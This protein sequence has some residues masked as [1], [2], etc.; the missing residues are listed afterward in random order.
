[1]SERLTMTADEWCLVKQVF[2]ASLDRP[3]AERAT[4]VAS[5]CGSQP[6]VHAAVLELLEFDRSETR[7]SGGRPAA[8]DHVLAPG[9]LVA[10]RFRVTRLIAAGGMGEVFEVWD[11]WLRLK[12]ALKTLRP[13]LLGDAEALQ[14]FKRE[15]LVARGVAHENVCRVFDFVEHRPESASGNAITPCF[16]MELLEGESLA[17][18]LCRRRPLPPDEA[19]HIARQVACG[20]SALHDRGIIHRDLKPSN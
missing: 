1:M 5:A 7:L 8:D 2:D 17:E 16:T 6:V 9:Q 20:L 11:E 18:L 13:E 3:E 15:L 12:I 4:F 19:L 14:R 10:G